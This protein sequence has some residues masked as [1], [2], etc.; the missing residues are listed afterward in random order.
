MEP[1]EGRLYRW[2]ASR[3]GAALLLLLPAACANRP[4]LDRA[5]MA[6][7]GSGARNEG[8]AAAYRVGCPDVLELGVAG[9]PDLSGPHEVGPDGRV[10]L[11]PLGRVRV[12]GLTPEEVAAQVADQAGLPPERVRVRVAERPRPPAAARR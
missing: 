6:E 8:V 1:G 12:E 10:E 9:R 5:L 4:Y 3:L 2:L 11:G 7:R